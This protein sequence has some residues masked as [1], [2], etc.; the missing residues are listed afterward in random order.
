MKKNIKRRVLAL[1]F[2]MV[3]FGVTVAS[4]LGIALMWT[5][6]T[7]IPVWVNG[8]YILENQIVRYIVYVVL[9]I[10]CFIAFAGTIY[11]SYKLTTAKPKRRRR[12][13]K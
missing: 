2:M 1:V 13:N 3:C 8:S 9:A 12:K 11:Y 10:I 5:S 6:S 4:G 7:F